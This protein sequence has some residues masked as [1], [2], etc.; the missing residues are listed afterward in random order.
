M[1]QSERLEAAQGSFSGHETF[2]LRYGW[3][4]KGVDA[5]REDPSVFASE[6][7]MV[8]L[9]VGKNM[10]RSIRHWCLTA[11]LIEPDTR[12]ANQR[13]RRLRPTALGEALFGPEGADPYLEDPATIWLLHWLICTNDERATTWRWAF[14]YYGQPEFTREQ[15]VKDL[16]AL[17]LH[18]QVARVTEP[19][20]KRDV[21]TFLHTYLPGRLSRTTVVEDTLDSPLVDLKLLREDAVGRSISFVRGPKPTLSDSVLGFAVLEFWDRLAPS[22]RTMSLEDLLYRGG[23]PGRLFKLD[24]PSFAERLERAA[25]W[26]RGAVQFDETAGLRQLLR[27]RAI[28]PSDLL[29]H[30]RGIGEKAA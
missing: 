26:S 19:S 5:V 7:A 28:A 21:D 13:G 16:G 10:V 22:Q 25:K 23:S 15:L 27:T 9:G 20:L 30:R 8:S 4:K 24:E 12:E 29:R 2:A 1:S 17:I 11:R 18:Q 14:G 3:P 6:N